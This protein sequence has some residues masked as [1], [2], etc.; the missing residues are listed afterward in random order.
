MKFLVD[1]NL[2]P[3]LAAWMSG[4]GHDGDHV[5]NAPG[6]TASDAVIFD[7]ELNRWL[8]PI[9]PE[10]VARLEAGEKLIEVV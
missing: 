2:P 8:E 9:L 7:A 1:A 5:F 4:H 10:I 6:H 3:G